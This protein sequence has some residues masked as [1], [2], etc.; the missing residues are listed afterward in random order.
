MS[1]I[2]VYFSLTLNLS[3]V[4]SIQSPESLNGNCCGIEKGTLSSDTYHTAA[5]SCS[6]I[7]NVSKPEYLMSDS[8]VELRPSS[9]PPDDSDLS[10]NEDKVTYRF[11]FHSIFFNYL[12]ISL[13][14]K[15]Y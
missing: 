13:I 4:N 6:P 14:L 11:C 12:I 1:R 5:S 8:G 2:N 10:S 3:K 9:M 15:C 7:L